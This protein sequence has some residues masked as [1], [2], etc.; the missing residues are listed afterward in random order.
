MEEY[1]LVS[2][3]AYEVYFPQGGR[4]THF[5]HSSGGFEGTCVPSSDLGDFA[6]KYLI[7]GQEEVTKARDAAAA[8]ARAQHGSPAARSPSPK[9]R[10]TSGGGSGV[11]GPMGVG[12]I[13]SFARQNMAKGEEL[14][15]RLPYHERS[16]LMAVTGYRVVSAIKDI[17]SRHSG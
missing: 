15:A 11:N 3:K 4:P 13:C 10:R 1:R 8:A 17:S 14:R 16:Q 2:P 7:V 9:R 12:R 6:S 5:V